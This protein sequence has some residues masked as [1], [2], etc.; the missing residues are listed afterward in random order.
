MKLIKDLVLCQG[1][2]HYNQGCISK[3]I[4]PAYNSKYDLQSPQLRYKNSEKSKEAFSHTLRKN[5]YFLLFS[6]V[7]SSPLLE[8][9]WKIL[10]C[11]SWACV[12]V[13]LHKKNKKNAINNFQGKPM[14]NKRNNEQTNK[15]MDPN[16]LNCFTKLR[17]Q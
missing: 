6:H 17:V 16:S 5:L 10:P 2:K 9:S 8:F 3:N 13:Q 12:G 7:L 11:H 15:Q 14:T 4:F 1:D